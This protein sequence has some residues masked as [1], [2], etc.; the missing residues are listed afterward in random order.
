MMFF[1][2]TGNKK[3]EQHDHE[4]SIDSPLQ[5]KL[6]QTLGLKSCILNRFVFRRK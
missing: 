4:E 1:G 3:A 2:C 5:I 6:M